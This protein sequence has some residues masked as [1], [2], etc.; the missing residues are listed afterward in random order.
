MLVDIE[1]ELLRLLREFLNRP[2]PEPPG[3]Q[4][5]FPLACS[6]LKG[7]WLLMMKE[8]EGELLLQLTQYRSEEQ[9]SELQTP[10]NHV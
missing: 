5:S 3:W 6:Y 9:T 7:K 8:E 4:D 10:I 2:L 1:V